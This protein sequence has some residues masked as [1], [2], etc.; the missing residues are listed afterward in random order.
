MDDAPLVKEIKKIEPVPVAK[1]EPVPA[2]SHH[3]WKEPNRF[4]RPL[5]WLAWRLDNSNKILLVSVI[6]ILNF[7]ILFT[8]LGWKK[9]F[10]ISYLGS[11]RC[12]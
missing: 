9:A 5:Y 3:H 7:A 6:G 10:L 11:D 4:I 8:T 12:R 1:A 2:I